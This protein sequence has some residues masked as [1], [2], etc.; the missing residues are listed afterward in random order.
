MRRLPC[1]Y[2]YCRTEWRNRGEA[3]GALLLG[4]IARGRHHRARPRIFGRSRRH[5]DPCLLRGARSPP[6][7]RGRPCRR[8]LS[9]IETRAEIMEATHALLLA[10]AAAVAGAINSV[11]GGGTLISF[12]AALAAGLPPI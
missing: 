2:G 5:P 8:A 12:P 4:R 10:G 7:R 9:R 1:G 11:A 6:A 3:G